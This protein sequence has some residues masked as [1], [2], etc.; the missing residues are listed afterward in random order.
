M[1]TLD[2]T[3]DKPVVCRYDSSI[4]PAHA[5][6]HYPVFLDEG[7]DSGAYDHPVVSLQTNA[8][9]N[10]RVWGELGSVDPDTETCQVY[11]KGLLYLRSEAAYD[12]ANNGKM[13]VY[14]ATKDQVYPLTIAASTAFA[15]LAA[16]TAAVNGLTAVL[17]GAI[18]SIIQEGGFTIQEDGND[19]NILKCR[20]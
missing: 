2:R 12:K 8:A 20:R 3:S 13:I 19:V 15:D 5:G 18:D 1:S 11:R 14:S 4:T 17:L 9:V 7:V 10:T 6:K 16:A